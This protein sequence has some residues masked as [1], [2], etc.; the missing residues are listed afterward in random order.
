MTF[1]Q[2]KSG[3]TLVEQVR[4]V[5]EED[6]GEALKQ[7]IKIAIMFGKHAI[8]Y[9]KDLKLDDLFNSASIEGHKIAWGLYGEILKH[10]FKYL[11]KTYSMTKNQALRI[12]QLCE[13]YGKKPHEHLCESKKMTTIEKYMIDEFVFNVWVENKNR[14][15][16]RGNRAN[17]K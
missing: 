16:E 14:E 12:A 15:V 6:K 9:P 13:V 4:G 8:V 10:S 5:P 11:Y 3:L 2:Y 7:R 17:G 1:F